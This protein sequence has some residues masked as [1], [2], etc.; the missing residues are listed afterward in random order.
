MS[1]NKERQRKGG[2]GEAKHAEA[3]SAKKSLQERALNAWRDLRAALE[4]GAAEGMRVTS[5][6]LVSEEPI[7]V[8]LT[9]SDPRAL[10]EEPLTSSNAR[11]LMSFEL[12]DL[13]REREEATQRVARRAA[14]AP[15]V[16]GDSDDGDRSEASAS[17]HDDDAI[18]VGSAADEAFTCVQR[19]QAVADC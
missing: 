16:G 17:S 10:D 15:N 13:S 1:D 8:N 5:I 12:A 19:M 6:E 18:E 14:V 2:G 11:E 3:G 7:K 4:V 9:I